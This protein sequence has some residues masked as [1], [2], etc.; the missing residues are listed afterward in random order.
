VRDRPYDVIVVGGRCA[1]SP[2]AALLARQGL[3]VAVLEQAEF[4]RDTLSSHVFEADGL[5]FLDRLGVTE[6]LAATGAPF[7][8][9]ADTNID[10]VR[11]LAGWPYR[12][13]E[14]G[15][16]ASVRRP[17]LDSILAR[18]AEEA[19]AEVHMGAKVVALLEEDG[20][21][22]GVRVAEDAREGE[23]HAALVVGADGRN[24]TVARLA[25]SRKYN[26]TPNQRVI[27]WT[28]FEDADT[29]S[30]PTFVTHRWDRRFVLGIPTDSGLYQVLILPDRTELDR[31][32]TDLEARFID[33]AQ[34]CEPVAA[35][36]A[37][38]RRVGKFMGA[39]RWEGYFRE[40]S[41]PGWVLVGDAGH[42]KDPA[43]GRGISDAFSQVDRLAPAIVSGLG[44]SGR[45]LDEA[46]A[47]WGRWRDAEFTPHYWLATDFGEAGHP[48]AVLPEIFGQLKAQGR[49]DLFYEVLNHRA[50]P[51]ELI[52]PSRLLGATA[53]LVAR[54]KRGALREMAMLGARELHRRRLN[55]WPAYAAPGVAT[56][57][58]V[59]ADT[60]VGAATAT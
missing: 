57:D 31:L 54:R 38:A 52:T 58:A 40:A 10:G 22:V 48:P 35:A 17:L 50:S 42:F 21:V 56:E 13:G 39:V 7:V 37:G 36:I 34:S 5:A 9:R 47:R 2:L 20:R 8:K 45:S 4:P 46:M 23:L 33:Y 41:G 18:T 12:P 3:R 55:R 43:P 30:E 28:Y 27:Y 60:E 6:E 53:R 16:V 44:R 49:S 24:S 19:G 59:P 32:R 1:G 26:V 14:P 29:G 25:G 51:M 11:V 15:G